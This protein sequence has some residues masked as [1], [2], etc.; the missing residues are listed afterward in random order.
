MKPPLDWM[1]IACRLVL[2]GIV[3]VCI[4]VAALT[5]A[6]ALV[7]TGAFAQTLTVVPSP[8]IVSDPYPATGP[9]PASFELTLGGTVHPGCVAETVAPGSVRMRCPASSLAA[10]TYTGTAVAIAADGTRS[11]A[12]Q[13]L[14]FVLTRNCT[15]TLGGKVLTCTLAFDH[16]DVTPPAT[17]YATV[18]GYTYTVNAGKLALTSPIAKAPAGQ[19][20]DCTSPVISNAIRY[21]TYTGAAAGIVSAC[22]AKP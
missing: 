20:C 4:A 6:L 7:S 5:V 22:I 15:Q 19:A 12:S 21:C 18:G 13:P 2:A 3:S 14:R 10:G 8:A 16:T 17:T 1:S 11:A 9:Q